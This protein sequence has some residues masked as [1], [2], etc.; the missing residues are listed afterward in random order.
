MQHWQAPWW[1]LGTG[2]L[3]GHVQTIVPALFSR[4]MPG[5]VADVMAQVHRERWHTPDGDFIDVD[6][7]A[8][9]VSSSA[10]LLVLFH[11]LEGS[12][13]SHYAQA[14]GAWA[15]QQGWACVVPHFRG[16]SGELNKAPRFYFAGDHEE[17]N[18]V[19]ERL[20]QR[21]PHGVRMAV[22]VSLGGNM[23]LRWAQEQ[24]GLAARCV[25]AVAAVSAPLDLTAAGHAIASGLSRQVYTRMFI[26]SMKPKALAKLRDYSG[27]YDERALRQARD[28]Y[29]YDNVVTAP[30]HGF[31]N[32]EDYWARCSAGPRLKEVQGLPTL[33]LNARNDPFLPS[34]ALPGAADV[35]PWVT[36]WQPSTGG[37]VGFASGAWPGHVGE[38]PD[39]V[40]RWL[41]LHAGLRCAG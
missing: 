26:N 8:P 37:H 10:P 11:G 20:A 28:L 33:V 9:A 3:G 27:L 22:G 14:F 7:L 35:S 16:C 30:L 39:A 15:R 5:A 21:H 17:V 25:S 19:L 40:G 34:T 13:G 2:A 41:A 32:T 12:S 24:Q 6:W 1:G 29:D 38:M 4:H 23:L 36:L 18:W 31:A